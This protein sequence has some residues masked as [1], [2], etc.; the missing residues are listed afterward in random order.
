MNNKEFISEMALR[1]SYTQADVQKL[2][3]TLIEG[4]GN[5]FEA[6]ENVSLSGFG[7]FEVKK[8]MER[9]VVNPSTGLRMLVPPKLVLAFKPNASVKEK[10]KNG[11]E[12]ND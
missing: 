9:V 11:G 8:R 5:S 1:S 6:G 4:M 7:T 2:V 3:N 10:L 12:N